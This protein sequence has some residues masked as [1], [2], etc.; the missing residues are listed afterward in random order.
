MDYD[1]RIQTYDRVAA[2]KAQIEFCKKHNVPLFAP[3]DPLTQCFR[4]QKNIYGVGGV[5]VGAASR[6]HITGCPFCGASFCD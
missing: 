2:Q 1:T 6:M 5:S 3:Q 4:C